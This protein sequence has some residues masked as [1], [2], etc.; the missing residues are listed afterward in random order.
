[1]QEAKKRLYRHKVPVNTLQNF[2][3]KVIRGYGGD[4]WIWGGAGH[5]EGYGAFAI[6]RKLH[7]AHRASY[8]LHKGPIPEGMF[9]CHSCD[10]KRCVNPDHLWAGNQVANMQDCI[11][12]GRHSHGETHSESL[13]NRKIKR[14]DYCFVKYPHLVP[15][16]EK[17]F[18]AKLTEEKV[19]LIRMLISQG[20][21]QNAIAKQMGISTGVISEIRHRKA[22]AHVD[23]LPTPTTPTASP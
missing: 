14:E 22:W 16:G 6:N 1:M 8:M 18:F 13:R 10:V 2:L 12:K 15:R 23:P 11:R 20:V 7:T 17:N 4:C 19:R 21:K 5:D 9:I 3:D